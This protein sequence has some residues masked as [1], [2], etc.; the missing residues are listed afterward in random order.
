[1]GTS[2]HRGYDASFGARFNRFWWKCMKSEVKCVLKDCLQCAKILGTKVIPLQWGHQVQAVAPGEVL[3]FDYLFIEDSE[4]EITPANSH[5]LLVL[6]DGF[7]HLVELTPCA[8]PTAILAADAVLQWISRH[9]L[10][11]TLISTDERYCER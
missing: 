6:K 4:G 8:R 10:P 9:G 1:M 11:T 2:G 7:S 5:Y 3:H